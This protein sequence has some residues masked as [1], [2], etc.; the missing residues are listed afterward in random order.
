MPDWSDLLKR[1]SLIERDRAEHQKEERKRA[2]AK[3]EL[4]AWT[5]EIVPKVM[6]EFTHVARMHSADFASRTGRSISVAYPV[7]ARIDTPPVL[8]FHVIALTLDL[9][10]VD[11]YSAR[12]TG[13]L[14][15]LH[16]VSL[17]RTA[18]GTPPRDH[19]LVSIP[20]CMIA[21]RQDNSHV[22]LR[23]DSRSSTEITMDEVVYLGFELLISRW[24]HWA[25]SH[26]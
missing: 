2:E 21:C 6:Q 22:L 19:R 11:V 9:A 23:Q 3:A 25:Q 24:Q 8:P 14:P 1:V 15:G 26:R 4:D 17:E 20:A 10:E 18:Q 5:L 12:N 16:M 13:G 7:H